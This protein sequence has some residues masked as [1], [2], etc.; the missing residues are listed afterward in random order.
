[1]KSDART[2]YTLMVLKKA[3]LTLLSEKPL[4]KISVKELCDLAEIN[5][6]TFYKHYEDIFALNA[7]LEEDIIKDYRRLLQEID[8]KHIYNGVLTILT[9]LK[10]NLIV[11]EAFMKDKNNFNLVFKIAQ[12]SYEYIEPRLYIPPSLNFDSSQKVIICSYIASGTSGII[13]YWIHTGLQE[14]PKK[15]ASMIEQLNLTLIKN[16]TN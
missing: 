2:R 4:N 3:F 13:Q 9:S 14:H 10:E 5:R 8:D 12:I 7:S 11:Y 15:I 6:T 16:L 1:M